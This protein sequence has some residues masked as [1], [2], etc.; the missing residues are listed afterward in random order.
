ME[1][2]CSVRRSVRSRNSQ[3][4]AQA[5]RDLSPLEWIHVKPDIA[6]EAA[7]GQLREIEPAALRKLRTVG[8]ETGHVAVEIHDDPWD[9]RRRL[10]RVQTGADYDEGDQPRDT[11]TRAPHCA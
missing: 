2:G 3:L 8:R 1:A 4:S 5:E 11:H 10:L 6:T 9:T 7:T